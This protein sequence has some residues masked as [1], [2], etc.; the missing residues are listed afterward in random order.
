MKNQIVSQEKWVSARK[1]LL[2]KEKEFTQLRD[3]LSKQRQKL[4]W[5]LI[6]KEYVFDG[7]NG[8]ESLGDLFGKNSQLIVYHFMLDP[9]WDEGCKAC[10]YLADHYEP[11]IVHLNQRDVTFVTI[12]R[13]QL[14]KVNSFKERMGWKFKWASSFENDFNHDFHVTFSPEEQENAYYNYENRP[15][16]MSEAP[17]LSVFYKDENGEIYHTYSTYARGLDMFITAYH[18]LDVVPKGR[19]EEGL[20]NTMAWIKH[21]DK[22]ED[23]V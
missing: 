14:E 3:Q 12:S 11:A 9:E 21:R 18:F 20:P 8:K 15:F 6:E 22:Y 7:P 17:G 13:A 19:D 4:P 1:E 10:S 2:K 23:V 16:P 5:A